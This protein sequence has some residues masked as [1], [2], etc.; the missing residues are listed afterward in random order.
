MP[1]LSGRGNGA[2]LLSVQRSWLSS[3]VARCRFES[4]DARVAAAGFV[5]PN[6]VSLAWLVVRGQA[7]FRVLRRQRRAAKAAEVIAA[8]TQRDVV[9]RGLQRCGARSWS[10]A[11]MA[12]TSCTSKRE[13]RAGAFSIIPGNSVQSS[14]SQGMSMQALQSC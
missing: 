9:S 5:C 12:W 1:A 2:E 10:S 8:I 11:A 6:E 13:L 7:G 14:E 4:Y 3:K